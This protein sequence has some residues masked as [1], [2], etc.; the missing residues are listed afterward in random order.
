MAF[1]HPG[2]KRLLKEVQVLRTE[3]CRICGY[4]E[5][6]KIGET[7]YWDLQHSSL[8][9]CPECRLA[10]LDP[11]LTPENTATGC[12]A[13]YLNEI[14][15]TSK[16]EQQ[17]NLVRNYRRGIVFAG[18][19]KM[20]GYS[21]R[22]I[23]EFGP[24]SGY[25]SAGIMRIFPGCKITVVDIVK[26]VLDK[27][28]DIHGFEVIRGSPEDI[29][30]LENRKFDL[31][32]ARDILEHVTDIG[33]V[34]K[35]VSSLL[36]N[37][38]LFHFLTPNGLEDLWG[39]YLYWQHHHKPSELLI[40]HVNYFDG[41]GLLDFLKKNELY[42]DE[43]F[44]Y[45]FK[46]TLRGK[47]WRLKSSLEANPSKKMSASEIIKNNEKH[48]IADFEKKEVLNL[49]YLNTSLK[50]L[51]DL[52]CIHKHHW[53]IHFNPVKNTGHEISGLFIHK[54]ADN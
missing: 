4:K 20:K 3:P 21:P 53:W 34:I 46:T 45:Q 14:I 25:F 51:T 9:Y 32:I 31:V 22:E 49:W 52:Y 10:Q 40:N 8:I 16:K 18:N 54:A 13:Y 27:N 42:P 15:R 24:G 35:N 38:G 48:S 11:M 33:R 41:K 19:L 30:Y 7:D 17:R 37:G 1:L 43:Y 26:D 39:H 44:T 2:T 50:W 6:L 36:K 12:T 5:G 28:R 23:L 29:E 47:G